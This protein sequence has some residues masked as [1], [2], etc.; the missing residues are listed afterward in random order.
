MNCIAGNIRMLQQVDDLLV[1]LDAYTY[2]S[3]VEVFNG[4]TIGQ[5]VRHILN[6]YQSVLTGLHTGIVD[7]ARRERDPRVEE[8]PAF[9]REAFEEVGRALKEVDETHLLRVLAD[10]TTEEDEH[11]PLLNSS[12]GRELMFA[13]DHAVH[14]LA[15]IRIGLQLARPDL[16]LEEELGVAPSTLKFQKGQRP[17][18]A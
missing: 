15:I 1:R 11:R 8:S 6:F 4:S 9:A 14:H 2:A 13:F 18:S 17:G 12:A 10:F 16:F 5:H 3:P 7:Y